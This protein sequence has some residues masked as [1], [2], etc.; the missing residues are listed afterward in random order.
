MRD[1]ERAKELFKDTIDTKS[2]FNSMS[3]EIAREKLEDAIRAREIPLIFIMGE[4]GVG[5]SYM[6]HVMREKFSEM[7]LTVFISRPFFD[8]RDFYKTLYTALGFAWEEDVDLLSLE[9]FLIET[10]SGVSHVIFIDEAQLLN[11]THMEMLRVLSDTKAFQFVIAMHKMEC[12]A[13]FK[14]KQ[15]HSRSMIIEYGNL[16]EAEV[17]R[18]IQSL[19]L[20]H[21][22]SDVA[23]LFTRNDMKVIYKYTQGNFRTLKRFFYTVMKLLSY[24]KEQKLSHYSKITTCLLTMAALDMGLIHDA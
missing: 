11:Q 19:F 4:P 8:K 23:T 18:Y 3:A 22:L 20:M 15:W 1:F 24:A 9:N 2:Y 5:K 6:L 14:Q 16:E 10:Y 17:M 13:L 12:I 7:M 21:T